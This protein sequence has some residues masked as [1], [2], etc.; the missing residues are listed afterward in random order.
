ML[1]PVWLA[2]AA[3]NACTAD[4]ASAAAWAA[5]LSP[6]AEVSP[7]PLIDTDRPSSLGVGAVTS[8]A[9][10]PNNACTALSPSP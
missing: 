5:L 2:T 8:D 1:I 4:W 9:A 6:S 3:V 10:L 7:A